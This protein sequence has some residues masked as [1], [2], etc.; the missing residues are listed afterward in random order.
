MTIDDEV[1]WLSQQTLCKSTP[2]T[3]ILKGFIK[4][5]E[6]KKNNQQQ[7]M[8]PFT[9][10]SNQSPPTIKTQSI[11][12][13]ELEL[14]KQTNNNISSFN[15][16]VI[17]TQQNNPF[18]SHQESNLVSTLR[19]Q[20]NNSKFTKINSSFIGAGNIFNS[21][22]QQNQKQPL[23]QPIIDVETRELIQKQRDKA[24]ENIKKL[25]NISAYQNTCERD[26]YHEK[27]ESEYESTYQQDTEMVDDESYAPE[28][29][30]KRQPV[31]QKFQ[32]LK[33]NNTNTYINMKTRSH[34]QNQEQKQQNEAIKKKLKGN[35]M[36]IQ[37][38]EDLIG[39]VSKGDLPLKILQIAQ[40]KEQNELLCVVEFKERQ[41]GNKPFYNVM[42]LT[43]IKEQYPQIVLDFY[44]SL[45][46]VC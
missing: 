36:E 34:R 26:T 25:L 40:N 37:I 20:F 18:L 14:N 4:D 32:I 13:N 9:N 7:R 2:N 19:E 22:T 41:D 30:H 31:V 24:Q 38:D 6:Q 11:V 15:K 21:N 23:I 46:Q 1:Y 39:D 43:E 17:I 45:I 27:S 16:P 44:K 28:N 35:R 8:N 3:I 29:E 5:L 33:H 12:K 10:V 42:N